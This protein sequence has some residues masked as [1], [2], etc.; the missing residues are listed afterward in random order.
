MNY[1]PQD[2]H[3][4]STGEKKAFLLMGNDF[5]VS[6]HMWEFLFLNFI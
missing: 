2:K 6:D 5:V 4:S 1:F 3:I